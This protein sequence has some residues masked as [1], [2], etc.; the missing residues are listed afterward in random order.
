MAV[1]GD[2]AGAEPAR[3]RVGERVTIFKRGDWWWANFTVHKKQHRIALNTRNMKRARQDAMRMEIELEDGIY[4]IPVPKRTES[5][6]VLI[7]AVA[8]E[9]LAHLQVEGV[10]AA[11]IKRYTPELERIVKFAVDHGAVSIADFNVKL[12]DAYRAWRV[13]QNAARTTLYHESTLIKQ[14]LNFAVRH[15]LLTENPLKIAKLKKPKPATQVVYTLAQIEA[16]L[17][18]CS[19]RWRSVFC[20]AAFTGMR[21]GEISWLRWE[22][23]DFDNG[24]IDV[25]RKVG[26]Q[27][28]DGDDRKIPLH[29]RARAVLEPVKKASGWVFT[30][31]ACKQF[32]KG[33]QQLSDRRALTTLKKALARLDIAHG[34]VHG[35]RRFFVSYCANNGVPPSILASWTGHSDLKMLMR[36]YKLSEDESVNAMLKLGLSAGPEQKAK[37]RD[38][39]QF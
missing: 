32:P 35:F 38:L 5:T 37:G 6:P 13:A 2:A 9:F 39:A 34:N 26:W 29:P 3:E 24:L 28:K 10:S 21:I 16:I 11:T 12:F 33:G 19:V 18:I 4:Q 14:F 7:T 15:D 20:V 1:T 36:Y 31:K 17:S 30:G 8:S 22:D 23:V 25:H 27:P